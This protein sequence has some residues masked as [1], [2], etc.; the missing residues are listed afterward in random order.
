M[1]QLLLDAGADVE[2]GS[3]LEGSAL[4]LASGSGQT[5]IAKL[6]ISRGASVTTSN[7]WKRPFVEAARNGHVDI[8]RMLLNEDTRTSAVSDALKAAASNGHTD[9]VRM[10]L[11]EDTRTST[12]SDALSAA[13]LEGHGDVVQICFHRGVSINLLGQTLKEGIKYLSDMPKFVETLVSYGPALDLLSEKHQSAITGGNMEQV[14]SLFEYV[15]GA[16]ALGVAIIVASTFGQAHVL[17]FL[18]DKY[19][20]HCREHFHYAEDETSF[21]SSADLIATALLIAGRR[22]FTSMMLALLDSGVEIDANALQKGLQAGIEAGCTDVIL[23]ILEKGASANE[24]R[25][26]TWTGKPEMVRLLLDHGASTD[27][28][29][30]HSAGWVASR[31]GCAETLQML[32]DAVMV[33]DW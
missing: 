33:A 13:A 15:V 26:A 2:G 30:Y 6:L 23:A 11:N 25:M 18:L 7:S 16:D 22:C 28:E 21:M 9:I 20:H 4:A 5:D 8:V 10:L 27:S 19:E 31:Y 17:R 14:R 24:L 1:V 29:D 3:W 32:L 12:V